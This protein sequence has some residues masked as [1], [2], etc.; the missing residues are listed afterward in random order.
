MRYSYSALGLFGSGFKE[1]SLFF[2]SMMQNL[3]DDKES[4]CKSLTHMSLLHEICT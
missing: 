2:K 4:G 1:T 3:H